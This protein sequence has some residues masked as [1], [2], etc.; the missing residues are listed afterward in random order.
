MANGNK[1]FYFLEILRAFAAL[2]VVYDHLL[3][4]WPEKN[5]IALPAI[6]FIQKYVNQPLGIIQDFG[7]LGVSIFFLVSGFIITH[8]SLR[9]TPFEFVIKRIFR[10]YPLLV[11]ATILS[12]WIN[13]K[14]NL[15]ASSSSILTNIFLINYWIHPHIILVATAWTLA[16]EIIFY[17][18][19]F[20]QML[21]KLGPL[22]R[23][24][25]AQ[26]AVGGILMFA[27]SMGDNF[28]L[29]SASAAYMPYLITGQIFYF[30]LHKRSLNLPVSI[31]LLIATYV[32]TLY[33]I[34]SIHTTFSPIQN[35]YLLSFIYAIF[36]FLIG[37]FN[38]EKLRPNRIV[39]ALADTSYPLYLFHVAIGYFIL[40]LFVPQIGFLTA[41]CL[42]FV[43]VGLFVTF[44]HQ[45]IE[46][47][48]LKFGKELAEKYFSSS[49]R[50]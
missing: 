6:L 38:N 10:I 36:I 40:D 49:G 30:M 13:S 3:A 41:L 4:R 16:I 48:A 7:W 21:A 43:S 28:F 5:A 12:A 23:I 29:F 20:L 33:G 11:I 46:K 14:Q 9:E 31:L 1:Q 2:L 17:G 24:V 37:Y 22:A 32:E 19:T 26:L 27:R 25:S 44:I 18:F 42:A 50:H 47:P 35:S 45:A 8:V 15:T 39:N 34:S